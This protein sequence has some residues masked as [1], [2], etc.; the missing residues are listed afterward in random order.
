M[1]NT[2]PVGRE[3]MSLL[4]RRVFR[5]GGG[6]DGGDTCLAAGPLAGGTP[7]LICSY[8]GPASPGSSAAGAPQIK[9]DGEG[10]GIIESRS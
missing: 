2:N 9:R 5:T 7:G 6:L 3:T 10:V 4:I 1:T 8:L